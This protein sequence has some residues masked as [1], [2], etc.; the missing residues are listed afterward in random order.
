MREPLPG[1]GE[2]DEGIAAQASAMIVTPPSPNTADS[3]HGR[4]WPPVRILRPRLPM[5]LR[6]AAP[7]HR[8]PIPYRVGRGPSA[9]LPY[10]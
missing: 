5:R 8:S 1:L 4:R 7:G 9:V 3:E 6:P 2:G 10:Y